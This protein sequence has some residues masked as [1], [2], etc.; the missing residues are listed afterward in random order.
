MI[1]VQILIFSLISVV[2][3]IPISKKCPEGTDKSIRELKCFLYVPTQKSFVDA[4]SYCQSQG[5]N[6]ASV[7]NA[8]DNHLIADHAR[9]RFKGLFLYLGAS[10]INNESNT[11]SWADESQLKYTNWLVPGKS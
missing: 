11:W 8:L 7:R 4:Q 5:G 6:L 1:K 9:E 2:S 10:I 3:G